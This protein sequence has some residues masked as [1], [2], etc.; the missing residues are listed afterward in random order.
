MTLSLHH[1]A[2]TTRN[3]RI[4]LIFYKDILGGEL[5]REAQWDKGQTELDA[6]TGLT[7]SVGRVALLRFG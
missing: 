2:I 1:T 7:N 6:R 3:Y 4:M 5:I